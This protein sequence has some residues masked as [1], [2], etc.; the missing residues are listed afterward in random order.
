[1]ACE[2]GRELAASSTANRTSIHDLAQPREIMRAN[3]V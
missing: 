3:M 1:M 2:V